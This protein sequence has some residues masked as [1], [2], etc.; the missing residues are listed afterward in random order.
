MNTVF[1]KPHAKQNPIIPANSR[2][3]TKQTPKGF[4]LEFVGM[5]EKII[6]ECA[7]I[8]VAKHKTLDK[9]KCPLLNFLY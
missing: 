6:Y 3:Y 5:E 8:M 9:T 4:F 7:I 2:I 1:L